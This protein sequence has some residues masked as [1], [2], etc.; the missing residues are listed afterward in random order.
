MLHS[1]R[2]FENMY[3][4]WGVKYSGDG[5]SPPLPPPPQEEYPSGLDIT[6]ALDP[7]VEEEV[8]FRAA[9]E[10]QED[11]Q[12]AMANSDEEEDEDDD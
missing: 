9:L 3:I 4:G 8:E 12:E 7:T 5:Y 10:E 11:S 6:E 2:K 1:F